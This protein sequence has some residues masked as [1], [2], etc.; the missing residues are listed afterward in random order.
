MLDIAIIGG[1]VLDGT[2]NTPKHNDVGIK[3]GMIVEVAKDLSTDANLVIDATH[4]MVAPGF[5]DVH[6][7]C[8]LVPFM[9]GPIRESRIRQGVTTELIGQCGLGSAPHTETM[10]DWR[11][12]L[13]P[14]LGNLPQTWDW[15]NFS[16]FLSDLN[17]A[18]KSNNIVPLIG[19]GAIRAQVLGLKNVTPS[20]KDLERMSMIVEEAMSQGAL[21]ISYGLAYLPGMFAPKQEL[22]ALSSVVAA[23]NGIMMIH[24]RSHSR[25]VREGMTEALA[26]AK[27]SGVKLQISHMR[28]YA[29]PKFGITGQELIEM[30]EQARMDG[31]DVTFDQHPY[32]AGSTLLSQILP[33]WAKEGGSPEIIRRLKDPQ[34]RARLK[35]ELNDNGPDYPGWDNFVGMVGW[36]NIMI[37]STF[38]QRNKWAEGQ[39][40]TELVRKT[41]LEPTKLVHEIID[42]IAELL[43][44][45]DC[46]CSMVLHN[47]FAEEDI[48]ALLKHP[49]CQ[50]GSDGIPTGKPHPRLYGTYPKF[51][52][53]YVRDKKLMT[54]AEGIKRI[55]GDPALRLNLP[56]K[57]FVK[58]GYDADLVIFEPE[59]INAIENFNEPSEF[60]IGLNFTLVHGQIVVSN[61]EILTT[62]AGK[63]IPKHD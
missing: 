34:Q 19:H 6:S 36:S 41:G 54:W 40:A 50:I 17:K 23:H 15:P 32:R 26:V 47:L 16:S 9:S 12:Y 49:L 3:D 56:N 28:S 44:S 60:P 43:I 52:G 14:I 30:V 8:D 39:T 46:R 21:G 35:A 55:T 59:K 11:N 22:V 4:K 58:T 62:E 63:L 10:Q 53:E 42:Q 38:N 33:P 51:L 24:I 13:A 27:E 2:G 25:Q 31:V 18:K 48:V 7:H 61:G 37:S 29:N 57:G 20:A 45:E 1:L 5:I